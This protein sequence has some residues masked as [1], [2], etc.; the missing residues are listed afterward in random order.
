M[1]LVFLRLGLLAIGGP[2][3]QI[4]MIRDEVVGR[5]GWMTQEQFLDRLGAANL[6]PG[7]NTAEITIYTGFLRAGWLGLVTAGVCFTLPAA[8]IVTALAWVYVQFGAVPQ[9][10]SLLSGL[11]PAVVAVVAHAI[12]RLG[13]S[14]A[15]TPFLGGLALLA[16]AGTVAGAGTLTVIVGAGAIGGLFEWWRAG[17]QGVVTPLALGAVALALA[18]GEAAPALAGPQTP[19]GAANLG[20]VFLYFL[21]AGSMIFGGGV[22]LVALLQKD[23]VGVLHWVTSKQLLDAV[24]VGW[25]TPGPVFTTATFV[26]YV[27]LGWKGAVVA[28]V[29]IFL[30]SFFACAASGPL[31]P[32]LRESRVAGAFL[33]G[34]NSASIALMAAV[35]WDLGR[36]ALNGPVAIVLALASL[37]V[38]LRF[39]LN[40]AWVILASGLAGL[41]FSVH[42]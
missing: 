42:G 32:K 7:P 12:W 8:C 3:A 29:G 17:R 4:A 27:M 18:A 35:G 21:R 36:A 22:V 38:L 34:V 26:G 11:K 9:F 10:N 16:L 25:M 24:A 28:T 15:R 13:R 1:A 30:P 31:I 40:A 33:D 39:N 14:A 6:I 2:P 5:R 20:N 37:A 23:L 19:L 41:L